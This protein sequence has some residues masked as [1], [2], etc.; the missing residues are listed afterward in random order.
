MKKAFFPSQFASKA[1]ALLKKIP[2]VRLM[3]AGDLV[4]DEAIYGDTERVSREAPVLILR[5]THT[6]LTPGGAANAANNAADLGA[7]VYPLGVVG[8]DEQGSKLLQYFKNKK[9]D[10]SGLISV[11][12]RPTTVKSRIMAGAEHTAH[13]QVIRIDKIEDKEVSRDVEAK[14]IGRITAMA[15]KMDALLI[16]DYGL[17]TLTQAVRRSL[18]SAFSGKVIT[19]DSRHQLT[20]YQGATLITPNIAE[21]GPAA[22]VEIRDD[23]SLLRAGQKLQK[24]LGCKV[25]ITKGP[26]GMTLFDTNTR[27]THLPIF[28]LDQPVDPTG[29]GDTVASTVTMALAAGADLPLAA[30]VATVA[31]G[32]VVAKRGTATTSL[33]EIQKALKGT[34]FAVK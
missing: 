14:L 2:K 29:A 8:E 32:L 17:G 21:A 15:P 5:Y 34:L 18:I 19:V 31:A 1:T 9:I 4:V 30:S 33:E 11:K 27:V 10:T 20:D 16:S 28:G 23:E 25:L 13:Q 24:T 6:N 3:V 7:Q 12:N 22:G 26:H